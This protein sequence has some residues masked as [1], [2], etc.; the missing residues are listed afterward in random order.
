MPAPPLGDTAL[1]GCA[2]HIGLARRCSGK[3][4]GG[5]RRGLLAADGEPS[6]AGSEEGA[7]ASDDDPVVAEGE[8][9]LTAS[10][11]AV[12]CTVPPRR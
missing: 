8:A 11:S 4:I 5:R 9:A 7:A 12:T 3:S 10:S 2:A 1:R 6:P